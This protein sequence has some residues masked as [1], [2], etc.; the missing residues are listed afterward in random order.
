MT[1]QKFTGH[2][3][4][5]TTSKWHDF[6]VVQSTIAA[7]ENDK[8][9]SELGYTNHDMSGSDDWVE[10]GIA[11]ITVE[12]FP[13]DKIVAKQVEGLHEQ[14][15]QHRIRAHEAEQAILSQ[16]SKLQALTFEGSVV[17]AA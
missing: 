11:T 2:V 1:T 13:A 15:R 16:I 3:K 14:L 12:F 9:A 6:G 5:W 8:A 7:G 17:E 10:V 4:A